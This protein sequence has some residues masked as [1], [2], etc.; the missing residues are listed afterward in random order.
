[1]DVPRPI[2]RERVP[3]MGID[4]IPYVDAH[5]GRRTV[6]EGSSL[7]PRI[8]NRRLQ[9]FSIVQKDNCY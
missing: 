9:S 8:A 3:T 5:G 1:M 2:A 7:C 4:L 6:S